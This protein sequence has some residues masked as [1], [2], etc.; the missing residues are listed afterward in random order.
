MPHNRWKRS[1]VILN[2]FQ[3]SCALRFINELFLARP[4]AT[5]FIPVRVLKLGQRHRR[6]ASFS[7]DTSI[8]FVD[9]LS[10]IVIQYSK[11]WDQRIS[12]VCSVGDCVAWNTQ[13][14]APATA[15]V[16][17]STSSIID[18]ACTKAIVHSLVCLGRTGNL[19]S[20]ATDDAVHPVIAQRVE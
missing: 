12:I 16:W 17:Y 11:T 2:S 3:Q 4:H 20:Q 9:F 13:E 18:S 6:K 7:S 8:T 15:R 5:D 14:G 19:N 10:A 1:V